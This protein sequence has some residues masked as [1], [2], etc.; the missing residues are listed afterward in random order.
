MSWKN[1]RTLR[2]QTPLKRLRFQTCG[3]VLN[4]V[5]LDSHYTHAA[6]PV[7]LHLGSNQWMVYFTMRNQQNQSKIV[8]LN[9]EWTGNKLIPTGT[10]PNTILESSTDFDKDG[11]SMGNILPMGSEYFIYTLNWNLQSDVPW[12]NTIGMASASSPAGPF[13]KQNTPTIPL[14]DINPHS[15]SYPWVI[16]IDDKYH[17]YFGSN[18]IWGPEKNDM[19]HVIKQAISHDGKTWVQQ[20]ETLIGITKE[21][22]AVSRPTVIPYGDKYLMLFS[23]KNTQNKYDMHAAIS[24]DG[25]IWTDIELLIEGQTES[26]ESEERTYPALFTF[27]NEIY[28]LYNGNEYGKTGF[29]LLKLI[30]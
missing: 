4:P 25:N 7:G 5:E 27:D 23:A 15:M 1:K 24:A 16:K 29:G 20:K 22:T 26:W 11:I 17:C 2:K 12:R 28:V 6:Y 13:V 8:A 18:G 14:S 3:R 30:A 19:N 10:R 9:F 21:R